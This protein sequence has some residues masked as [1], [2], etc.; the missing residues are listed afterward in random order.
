MPAYEEVCDVST[1]I[2]LMDAGYLLVDISTA[3]V[4]LLQEMTD[5]DN[6]ADGEEGA[7]DF[8]D[9]LV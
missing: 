7:S 9:S 6:L 3:V 4:G 2:S 5:I 8:V 1:Y